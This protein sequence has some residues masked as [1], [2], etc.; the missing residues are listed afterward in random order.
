MTQKLPTVW[1]IHA[2][3]AGDAHTLFIKKGY[4]ALGWSQLGDLSK[5]PPTRDAYKAEVA[6][7][8]P[9]FK[10]GAIPNAAGQM[11]RFVHE[12][13]VG[14]LVV[15]RSK[16]SKQVHIGQ[17]EGGFE[18]RPDLEPSYPHVRRTKWIK[19]I[20]PLDA[21]QG[22]RYEIGSAMSFFQVK[23]YA[24]EWHNHLSSKVTKPRLP[25]EDEDP[26]IIDVAATIEESTRDF[27]VKQLS[28][29]LKG[30]PF[31]AF[32]AHLL[33]TMGYRTRVSP[34]GA[35]G[36]VDIIAHRDELGFEPPIVRVQVK[37]QDGNIG[38]ADVAALLGTLA[39][40][41]YG[42]FVTLS[43]FTTPAKSFAKGK[44]NLRLID[45]DDLVDLV[46]EHYE[47]L[48]PRYKGILPLKRVYVP[49]PIE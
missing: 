7:H 48:E 26:T 23:T 13:Q 18:Y 45:R 39:A 6:Q 34:E 35:D 5:L 47:H 46:L 10:P 30:H 21:T 44:G 36:G 14:D 25:D 8:Y 1:G 3:A 22:A 20:D 29:E 9:E 49:E 41:D 19:S 31:A 40:G 17:I 11:F 27:I 24:D 15:Y 42:L 38:N 2:G 16:V 33:N 4:V 37:S 32:V 43:S 28:K 12:V